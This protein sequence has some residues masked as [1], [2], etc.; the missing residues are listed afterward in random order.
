M[1]VAR[2]TFESL[3][4]EP[5]SAGNMG[6][7]F[8]ELAAQNGD[9]KAEAEAAPPAPPPP[10]T[11]TE[12]ELEAAKQQAYEDGFMAGKSEGKREVDHQS[13]E[14]TV[15]LSQILDQVN[16]KIPAL[17]D[18]QKQFL[19]EKQ[20]EL[21]SLVLHC[22]G[23]L[24]LEALRKDPMADIELMVRE[25]MQVLVGSPELCVR[26]HPKLQ[27]P[28]AR[29]LGKEINVQGDEN[30][31]PGDCHIAWQNG[32]AKREIDHI[33]EQV[34]DVIERYFANNRKMNHKTEDDEHTITTGEHHG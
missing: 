17:I 5:G 16:E 26:V 31:S 18:Q 6:D 22:A 34:E 10:P 7:G 2:F 25:A 13:M 3:V 33:W 9:T 20:S 27:L 15:Q 1:Q 30:L 11:F 24:A 12:E 14:A 19:N 29:K 8:E 32:E 21:G 23:K 28:L 4:P